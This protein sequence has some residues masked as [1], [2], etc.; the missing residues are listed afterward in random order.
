MT[1]GWWPTCGC[2]V[3]ELPPYPRRPRQGEA[4]E[5]EHKKSLSVWRSQCRA[6]DAERRAMC[7]AERGRKTSRAVVLDPFG[8]AGT[9]AMVADRAQRDGLIIEANPTYAEMARIR[10][11]KDE[12]PLFSGAAE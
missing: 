3:G 8:G 11:K 7:D 2:E 10:I 6:V 12:M 4:S 1:L 9:T 5:D